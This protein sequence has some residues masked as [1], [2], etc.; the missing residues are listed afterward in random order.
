MRSKA[1]SAVIT[2]GNWL[3]FEGEIRKIEANSIEYIHVDVM[4][5]EFVPNYMVGPDLVCQLHRRTNVPLD[6]HPKA[7]RPE[8]KIGYFELRPGDLFS[9]HLESSRDP[10][11][12]IR[13]IRD[14]GGKA[15]ISLSP[16]LRL[17]ALEPWL[18]ELDFINLMCVRPGF[19]GQ[20][21]LPGSQER[22][23][24]LRRL[25]D[26]DGREL[27][28]EV[29]GNVSFHNAAWMSLLGADLF[30]AG[31]SSIYSPGSFQEHVT[32][33]REVIARGSIQ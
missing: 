29:D 12:C 2:C 4:D 15:G 26:R 32:Q 21:L 9:F 28:V 10:G 31:T 16:D 8:D 7:F 5:G 25:A 11:R 23:R 30:V 18:S 33:L 14:R 20:A 19:A 22:L 13:A 17:E 27:P 1:I 6:I 24:Q 3:D